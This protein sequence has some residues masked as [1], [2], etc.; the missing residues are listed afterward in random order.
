MD[1]LFRLRVE[2]V[3][4]VGQF[5]F[6]SM[7]RDYAKF[8]AYS[9]DF[10][11]AYKTK[12]LDELNVIKDIVNPK[13]LIVELKKVTAILYDTIDSLR[14]I[15]TNLEGYVYRAEDDLNII[16]KDFGIS[17]VRNKINN[18]DQ[19]ALSNALKVVLQNIADNSTAL[20]A[21]GWTVDQQNELLTKHNAII[22]G[23]TDQNNRMNQKE[24]LVEDNMDKLNEFWLM[25]TDVLK[26]GKILFKYES[27]EKTGE[28]TLSKL[29][30]RIRQD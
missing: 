17:E 25:M 14:P 4:V 11:E 21:K 3:P 30:S 26:T 1:R 23:N 27:E 22:V 28:Y 29:K 8:T 20:E 18:K 9:P 2:E 10:D 12:Y 5:V 6:D 16:P 19:E 15:M 24:A 7:E 13:T